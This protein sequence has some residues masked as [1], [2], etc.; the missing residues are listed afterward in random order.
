MIKKI[1][2]GISI[3]G[4]LLIV[5]ALFLAYSYSH[6]FLND[7]PQRAKVELKINGGTYVSL[8]KINPYVPHAAVASQDE[9]FYTNSGIDAKGTVRAIYYSITTG[10]RQGAS[11]ITEQLI[12][13]VYFS[14]I[15]NFKTDVITKFLAVVATTMYPKNDILELYLN[16]IY[17]G[18]GVYGIEKASNYYF[19]ESAINVSLAESSYLIAL[20]NAPSYLGE[21]SSQAVK[22][23][24]TVL[25]LMAREKYVTNTQLNNAVMDLNSFRKTKF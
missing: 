5:V 18:H 12:K 10:K 7:L 11:T 19:N 25:E 2:F 17:Y 23:A 21:N 16:S 4:I 9:G 24:R 13:N 8:N 1:V 20:I 6:R 3:T 14:D 15:D 22:I